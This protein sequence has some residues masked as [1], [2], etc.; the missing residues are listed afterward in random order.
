MQNVSVCEERVAA[1]VVDA[2][3]QVHR[4]LGPGLLE[5]VYE[6]CMCHELTNAGFRVE[7]QIPVPIVYD[8]L[9]FDEGFRLDLLVE[10]CIIVELKAVDTP[11]P[12]WQAQML[13]YLKLSKKR[14]GFLINFNAPLI[15]KGIQRFIA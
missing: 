11:H 15:K 13:S 5:R 4:R 14:L 2:A 1:G 7:R 6:A 8:D 9:K 3:F 12:F 10:D